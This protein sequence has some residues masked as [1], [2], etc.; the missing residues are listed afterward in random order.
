MVEDELGKGADD[1]FAGVVVLCYGGAEGVV[2][3]SLGRV[4]DPSE[5]NL[6]QYVWL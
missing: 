2:E 1:G 6:G 3:K 4:L 5:W